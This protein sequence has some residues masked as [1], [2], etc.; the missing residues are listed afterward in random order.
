MTTPAILLLGLPPS[1]LCGIDL[2]SFTTSPRFQGIK[3]IPPG[4]HF[5]F[6][7]ATAS[8]SVRHGFWFYIPPQSSHAQLIVRKWDAS[9]EEL[10]PETDQAALLRWRANLASVWKEGL[11]P[12][13]Q[14]ASSAAQSL[15]SGA[16]AEGSIVE[17]LEEWADLTSHITPSLLSRITGSTDPFHWTLT[18]ASCAKQD[19]DEIPGLSAEEGVLDEEKEL[20]F[21]KVDLMR[22]WRE[23]AVGRERTEGAIDKSWALEEV[24]KKTVTGKSG[25]W[26]GDVVGEMQL[27]FLMVLTVANYS[28]LEQW[29]RILGLVFTCKRA[30]REKVEWFAEV[31]ALL[32][33]QM[34]RCD[35]VEG[36]LFDFSDEGGALLKRLLKGF[37]RVLEEIFDQGDDGIEVKEELEELEAWLRTE[38]GWNLSDSY[39]RRG[40]L[41]L[42]DGEQVEMEMNDMEGEDERGEYAPVVV[43]L[44]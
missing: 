30:V 1:T 12:Y 35:D 14:S 15:G 24:V 9:R 37:K 28:C 17:E 10:V 22:T 2:L 6:T 41:E 19:R 44:D 31:V 7:G 25:E 34:K 21:L 23:G 33:R 42:E 20:G 26:G 5:V 43:E 40:M 3:G 32:R 29:K 38:Y 36:G 4:W 13:R 18:S 39:V 11:T 16:G 8:L 27:C